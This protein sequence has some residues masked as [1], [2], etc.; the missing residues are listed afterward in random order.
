MEFHPRG[1]GFKPFPAPNTQR[2]FLIA[3][4]FMTPRMF[5]PESILEY[6]LQIQ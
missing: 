4:I 2:L 1:G 5:A 6:R 3:R